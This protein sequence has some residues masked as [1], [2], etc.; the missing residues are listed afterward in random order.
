MSD[1]G[2]DSCELDLHQ[3]IPK[4]MCHISQMHQFQVWFHEM[5]KLMH[6]ISQMH[7]LGVAAWSLGIIWMT[8]QNLFENV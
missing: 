6:H 4:L 2:P 3:M 7:Q 1:L 8:H 5:S